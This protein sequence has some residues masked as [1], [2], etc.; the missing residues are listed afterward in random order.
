M[1]IYSFQNKIQLMN[2]YPYIQMWLPF[3]LLHTKDCMINIFL[4]IVQKN[5]LQFFF[6]NEILLK[7]AVYGL[8]IISP[9]EL[10]LFKSVVSNLS[11]T[12]DRFQGRHCFH[13]LVWGGDGFMHNLDPTYV[14][15]I[16]FCSLVY[17]LHVLIPNR[18]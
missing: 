14:G 9:K 13:G 7:N 2:R 6:K 5:A 1:V 18:P 15:S 10:K 16:K 17:C 12:R 11:G 3:F 4:I 8:Q